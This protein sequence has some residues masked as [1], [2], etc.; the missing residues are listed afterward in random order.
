MRALLLVV[1]LLLA[2]LASCGAWV[3]YEIEA[4]DEDTMSTVRAKFRCTSVGKSYNDK[5]QNPPLDTIAD[6]VAFI[7]VYGKDGTANNQWSKWTPS[8]ELKLYITNPA[9]KDRF[10]V[11]KCYFVDLSDA[12]EDE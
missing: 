6:A 8:G 3:C 4:K 12:P 10:E 2:S 7:P 5:A 9:L 1:G 11:G